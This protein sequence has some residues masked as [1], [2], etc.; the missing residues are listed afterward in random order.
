VQFV[1]G[2]GGVARGD[3]GSMAVND[4]WGRAVSTTQRSLLQRGLRMKQA[5]AVRR[6]A[7]NP[8]LFIAVYCRRR[9]WM[10]FRFVVF[11]ECW[12]AGRQA[13]R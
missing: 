1:F 11:A 7:K 10:E 6:C 9:K 2:G 8:Q 12:Q 3:E 5:G 4:L 13:G